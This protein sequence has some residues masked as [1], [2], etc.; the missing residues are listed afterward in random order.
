MAGVGRDLN[1]RRCSG[2]ASHIIQAADE[3]LMGHA[4]EQSMGVHSGMV[5]KQGE[6]R[7]SHL[8]SAFAGCAVVHSTWG[9]LT[10]ESRD[11]FGPSAQ[12]RGG[13]WALFLPLLSP[14]RPPWPC[15]DWPLVSPGQALG[16]L[17]LLNRNLP[18][19]GV[20]KPCPAPQGASHPLAEVWGKRGDCVPSLCRQREEFAAGNAVVLTSDFIPAPGEQW[21]RGAMG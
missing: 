5:R 9:E 19:N 4:A 15:S 8:P 3:L 18:S 7:L 11:A 1:G 2:Y 12:A 17:L 14:M 21:S 20:P 16:S 6:G 10:A 13:S